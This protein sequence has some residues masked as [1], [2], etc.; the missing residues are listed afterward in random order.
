LQSAPLTSR[1]SLKIPK[2]M[3][4]HPRIRDLLE[5]TLVSTFTASK[6]EII[7]IPSN[8]S[9]YDAFKVLISHNI[10]SAPVLDVTTKKYTG[11]LDIRD[12][13]SFVVFVDDDQKSDVPQNLLELVLH[14]CKLFKVDLDG[15][16][17]T[18][19]SRRNAFRSLHSSDNLLTVCQ[20]LST[21]LHRVPIVD[22]SGTVIN[23]IS[24]SSVIQFL[25]HHLKEYKDELNRTLKELNLGTKP[26]ISVKQDTLAIETF[27]LM[28]NK[29]I[30]GV[31]VVDGTGKFVGNTSASDLK[32]F[33]KT[34]SLDL[35]HRP[36][37]E[38]LKII[39]QE[40]IDIM[41]PTISCSTHDTLSTAI[42]KLAATKIHKI[43]VADDSDNYTPSAVV[44][45]TDI[46][47][48]LC[49]H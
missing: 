16:T 2:D 4:S 14:G 46:L 33:L 15:V 49:K 48:Y 1:N 20:L 10:L 24:Q 31:A 19:L 17:T 22:E 23:I 5:K 26:V 44:S 32:L 40:S 47:R 35:L 8:V 25:S 11:F 3:A 27:R 30:S 29:K 34:L 28:D 38:F 37:T 39:R 21:G 42:S 7:V 18:Y 41:S 9:P 36:I 45:I 43:F 13:V 12:L 6:A